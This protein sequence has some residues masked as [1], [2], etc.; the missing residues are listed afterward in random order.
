QHSRAAASKYNDVGDAG[1][2]TNRA[3]PDEGSQACL[4][5]VL[6]S[7]SALCHQTVGRLLYDRV[8]QSPVPFAPRRNG[9]FSVDRQQSHPGL[10]NAPPHFVQNAPLVTHGAPGVCH[11]RC[12]IKPSADGKTAGIRG[13]EVQLP[14]CGSVTSLDDISVLIIHSHADSE[15]IAQHGEI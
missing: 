5:E 15:T 12:E 3:I 6:G 7:K 10:R 4:S 13:H 11:A 9:S 1:T 14:G 8:S 2:G